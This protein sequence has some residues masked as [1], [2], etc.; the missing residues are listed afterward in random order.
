MYSYD[1][2]TIFLFQNMILIFLFKYL[3][4]LILRQARIE[5]PMRIRLKDEE[6]EYQTYTI[7]EY[8]DVSRR[9]TRT[10][11]DGVYITNNTFAFECKI[12]VFSV[13]KLIRLCYQPNNTIWLLNVKEN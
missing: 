8:R 6:G 3:T 1:I 9:G 4:H 13:K 2:A 5:I 11:P 10:M 7:K 12:L